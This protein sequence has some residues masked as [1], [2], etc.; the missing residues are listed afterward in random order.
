MNLDRYECNA[1]IAAYLGKDD[2]IGKL[3]ELRETIVKLLKFVDDGIEKL[4]IQEAEKA[5]IYSFHIDATD[6]DFVDVDAC[7]GC[8]RCIKKFNI[9]DESTGFPISSSM[10]ITCP[11]CGNKR[12]PRASDH[13]LDCTNSNEPDQPGSIF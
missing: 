8:H 12:C 3:R 5:G 4:S 6:R 13:R 9:V 2:P 1:L 7:T 10:M 11:I